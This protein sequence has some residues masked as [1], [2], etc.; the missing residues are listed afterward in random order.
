MDVTL[1]ARSLRGVIVPDVTIY[2]TQP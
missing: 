2:N 1:Y